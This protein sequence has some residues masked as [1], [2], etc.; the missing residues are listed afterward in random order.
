MKN[1]RKALSTL[2]ALIFLSTNAAFAADEEQMQVTGNAGEGQE[3]AQYLNG[4]IQAGYHVPTFVQIDRTQKE[5]VDRRNGVEHMVTSAHRAGPEAHLEIINQKQELDYNAQVLQAEINYRF[6]QVTQVADTNFANRYIPYADGKIEYFKNG[7]VDK[8]ENE[9][10]VDELGN[11]SRKNTYNMNYYENRLLSGYES[12]TFNAAGIKT[13]ERLYGLRYTAD[14]VYYGTLDTKANQLRIDYYIDQSVE[15]PSGSTWTVT[16]TTDE[17]TTTETKTLDEPTVWNRSIHWSTGDEHYDGKFLRLFSETIHDN[18]YGNH[19]F[20]QSNIEYATLDPRKTSSFHE[21]GTKNG[22][23]YSKDRYDITYNGKLQVLSY[24]DDLYETRPSDNAD[25]KADSHTIT[26]VTNE[27]AANTFHPDDIDDQDPDYL[28]RMTATSVK[29]D[30]DGTYKGTESNPAVSVTDYTYN[31]ENEL[32]KVFTL[33]TFTGGNTDDSSTYAGSTTT[34]YLLDTPLFYGT[35]V[36]NRSITTS[37]SKNPTTARDADGNPIFSQKQETSTMDY[38]RDQYGL[39][40]DAVDNGNFIGDNGYDDNITWGLTHNQYAIVFQDPK[41]LNSQTVTYSGTV[42]GS[43][44]GINWSSRLT[45]AHYA[46]DENG[47]VVLSSGNDKTSID[48]TTVGYEDGRGYYITKTPDP[49]NLA[50]ITDTDLREEVAATLKTKNITTSTD[51]FEIIHNKL[52]QKVN[53]SYTQEG[54][55]EEGAADWAQQHNIVK[56]WS[57]KEFNDIRVQYQQTFVK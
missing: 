2:V 23:D 22:I 13:H 54:A 16:T 51:A 34:D 19:E 9:R 50:A 42:N 41:L 37:N 3:A 56:P 47:L 31:D 24:T 21:A 46:L 4:K 44:T 35:P 28:T 8:I 18:L 11:V 49:E 29:T 7:L 36:A 38:V 39:L 33:D 55:T 15:L 52:K 10:V 25:G 6:S 14:S 1:F 57:D 27:Y 26:K 5:R 43:E 30:S 40:R 45:K 48:E 53:L 32:I 20:T 17:G 12:D